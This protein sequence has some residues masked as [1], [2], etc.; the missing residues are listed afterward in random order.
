MTF[1][2]PSA[3][4]PKFIQPHRRSLKKLLLMAFLSAF[5]PVCTHTAYNTAVQPSACYLHL[6]LPN[7][8][9]I[10]ELIAY[11]TPVIAG[12]VFG[13]LGGNGAGKT[14]R[15]TFYSLTYCT[16]LMI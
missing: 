2:N 10:V 8:C 3:E 4:S 7:L 13:L 15:G 11:L 16:Q 9:V 14:V 6:R 5:A 1:L 12:E